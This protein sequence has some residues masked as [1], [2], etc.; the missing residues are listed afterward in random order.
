MGKVTITFKSDDGKKASFE[1]NDDSIEYMLDAFYAGCIAQTYSP[2]TILENMKCY[3]D[4]AL[5]AL[6][7]VEK[8]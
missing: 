2:I 3:A 8:N 4:S 1:M 6:S 7:D 5:E